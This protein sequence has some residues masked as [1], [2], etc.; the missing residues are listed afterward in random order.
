LAPKLTDNHLNP[1][2]FPKM[3]V[4]FAS[5]VF[6]H[7]VVAGMTILVSFNELPHSAFDTIDFIDS[8]HKL[9]DIFNSRPI[10]TEV[11]NHKGT[12]CYS[13]PF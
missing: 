10:S 4:K 11:S 5:H 3:I 1:N 6:S 8:M 12:K 7:T 9:F 2:Y 13:L